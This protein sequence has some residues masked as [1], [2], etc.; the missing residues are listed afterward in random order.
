MSGIFTCQRELGELDFLVGWSWMR[1]IFTCPGE[2]GE[3]DFHLP[4]R[5]G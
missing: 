4:G 1:W 3:L 2:L 5:T